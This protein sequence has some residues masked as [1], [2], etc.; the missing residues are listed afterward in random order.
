[1]I[2]LFRSLLDRPLDPRHARAIVG[3]ASCLTLAFAGLVAFG[4]ISGSRPGP[5]EGE[6][7]SGRSATPTAPPAV[8]IVGSPLGRAEGR[9]RS[10]RRPA[11]R[12]DPQD[13]RGSPAYRRARQTL[14]AH[15]ALQHVPFRGRDFSIALIGADR[16]RAIVRILAATVPEARGH[17]RGFLRRYHDDGR[18]YEPHFAARGVR[19]SKGGRG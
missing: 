16:G 14:R 7:T 3:V 6:A 13:R 2:D 8:A 1:V 12:Q 19:R 17:W 15:R 4:V 10:D 11:A 18:S 5:R 9:G